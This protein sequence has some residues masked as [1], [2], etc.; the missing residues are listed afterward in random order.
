MK[1]ITSTFQLD[2]ADRT[3][4]VRQFYFLERVVAHVLIRRLRIPD[5][6]SCLPTVREAIL[7]DLNHR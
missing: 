5:T 6:F 3:M 7:A 4:L 2:I 1:L